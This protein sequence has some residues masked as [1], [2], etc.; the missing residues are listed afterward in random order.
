MQQLVEDVEDSAAGLA[1][2][3]LHADAVCAIRFDRRSSL[4]PTP[5]VAIR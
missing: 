1:S 3:P 5:F 2:R 4:L